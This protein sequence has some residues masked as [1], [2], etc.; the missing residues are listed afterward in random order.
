MPRLTRNSLS[1]VLTTPNTTSELPAQE[2]NTPSNHL[3]VPTAGP[4]ASTSVIPTVP[5]SS[6]TVQAAPSGFPPQ[7]LASTV[8]S[9][10]A[11]Q[12]TLRTPL[13]GTSVTE[14]PTFLPTF[15]PPSAS[16]SQ[17]AFPGT[18][19]SS[20][21]CSPLLATSM[22]V[23]H[24]VGP[25]IPSTNI[26]R[27]FLGLPSN[28]YTAPF[29]VGPG[30]TPIS[31]KLINSIVGGQFVDLPLLIQEASEEEPTCILLEGQLVV[32]WCRETSPSTDRKDGHF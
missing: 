22:P 27:P 2:M 13:T 20:P 1:T 28:S 11:L 26:L 32:R 15:V 17:L 21:S 8:S 5:V 29:V 4:E 16:V 9:P 19:L 14:A 30:F 6:S 18:S 24:S 3:A 25:T 10:L 31:P 12:P 23:A 7:L